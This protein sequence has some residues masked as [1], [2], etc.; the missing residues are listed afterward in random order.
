MESYLEIPRQIDTP[1]ERI[2]VDYSCP[3]QLYTPEEMQQITK[4]ADFL[5]G[6]DLYEDAFP[7]YL[8]IH[9]K[10]ELN[11]HSPKTI[12]NALI[13]CDRSAATDKDMEDVRDMLLRSLP[14]PK[15]FEKPSNWLELDFIIRSLIAIVNI[16]LGLR[17]PLAAAKAMS[18]IPDPNILLKRMGVGLTELDLTTYWYSRFGV[19]VRGPI[20][21]GMTEEQN[22]VGPSTCQQNLT[23]LRQHL[24]EQ[25]P[26]PF[27]LGFEKI[28]MKNRC[29]RE[30]L[31]WCKGELEVAVNVRA[32]WK[33][34]RQQVLDSRWADSMVIYLF[35][36]S[37]WNQLH[38]EDSAKYW[39]AEMEKSSGISTAE[40]L[41]T[42]SSLM[43]KA[44]LNEK[45]QGQIK[46]PRYLQNKDS[47]VLQRARDG[48]RLLS[49]LPDNKLAE[50]FLDH[51]VECADDAWPPS[52]PSPY[53]CLNRIS[54]R[55][56]I[57][58]ALSIRLPELPESSQ[59]NPMPSSRPTSAWEPNSNETVAPRL[60]VASSF[61]LSLTTSSVSSIRKQALDISRRSKLSKLWWWKKS[62]KDRFSVDELSDSVSMISMQEN[63]N[64]P[65]FTGL[66]GI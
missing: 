24:L 28:Y 36:W 54:T 4:A 14:D 59:Q 5:F 46:I 9:K 18:V 22:P 11:L 33:S 63:E 57:Q 8:L 62:S 37:Q 53:G 48:A 65:D 15:Q 23:K 19:T 38:G 26:G 17:N 43:I 40:F 13:A 31:N 52:I 34:L 47:D 55:N 61:A 35:L 3:V 10:R 42:A 27:E 7:L 64:C 50:N 66:R 56:F 21:T 6:C 60:S 16:Q 41:N 29:L 39:F 1:A 51:Y 20:E 32:A 49:T 44:S 2:R 58:S 30:C 45:E 12:L 25:D